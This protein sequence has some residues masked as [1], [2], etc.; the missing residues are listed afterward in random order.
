MDWPE[1]KRGQVTE[2]LKATIQVAGSGPVRFF[3][4]AKQ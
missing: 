2:V 4:A 3:F 1:V